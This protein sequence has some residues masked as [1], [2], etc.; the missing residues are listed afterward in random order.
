MIARTMTATLALISFAAIPAIHAAENV[1]HPAYLS[2]ARHP[3]GT[4]IV[5]RS[6]TESKARIL[7]TTTTSI[8]KEIKPEKVI[9]E[10]LKVSDATEG[11]I[12]S[13]P[14][15]LEQYRLFPLLGKTKKEDVG[16]PTG[17]IAQGEEVLKVDGKDYKSV[18]FD[19][20]GK[21]EGGMVWTSRI[22]MSDDVPGRL[23]KSVTNFPTAGTTV[24]VEL[25]EL[26]TPEPA[27]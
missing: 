9:L 2:W 23:L 15:R 4:T 11:L 7:T 19:T 20:K 8:L 27:K 21:G 24:T 14:E 25:L 17:A 26:Q 22:W 3:V 10:I 1:D 5:V 18:W 13:P 6:Q 12:K 16:K